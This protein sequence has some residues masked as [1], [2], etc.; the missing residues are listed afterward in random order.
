MFVTEKKQKKTVIFVK[1]QTIFF[2][3][4]NFPRFNYSIKDGIFFFF[5]NEMEEKCEQGGCMIRMINNVKP[6]A[7]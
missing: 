7:M 4:F 1:I 2:F 5:F 3:F 6:L